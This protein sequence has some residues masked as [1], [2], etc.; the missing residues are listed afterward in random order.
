LRRC[1]YERTIGF[2]IP[3]SDK[4]SLMLRAPVPPSADILAELLGAWRAAFDDESEAWSAWR[5]GEGSYEAFLA[6]LDREHVAAGTLSAYH[7]RF[8][9][10]GSSAA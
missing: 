2:M 8:H 10:A 4:L 5:A 1:R 7:A 9:A 6:A 3:I